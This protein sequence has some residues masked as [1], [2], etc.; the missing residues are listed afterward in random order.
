MAFQQL[1]YTSCEHGLGG[2]AGYQFNAIT[3]GVP[4]AVLREVEERTLYEPPRWRMTDPGADEPDAYPI[5][6]SYGV[7]ETTGTTITAHVVFSGVDYSGR[8]GNYFVHALVSSAP[9]QDFGVLLPVELWGAA[10][11]QRAPIDGTELPE[12]PGPLPRGVIDRPGVQAFLDARG[13]QDVLPELL[14]AIGR[15][16][17]GEQPVLVAS[18]DASENA[19]WIAAASYLMGE[20]VARRMT[21]TTYSHRP[22]YSAYHLV[23]ILAEMLPPDASSSFQLF[24]FTAGRRPGHEPHPLAAILASTGV[25]AAPGLWQQA[26]VFASGTEENLDDWLAP[27]AVAA[28]L[29]GRQL[30]AG[31]MDTVARWLPAAGGWLPP[32]HRRDCPRRGAHPGERSAV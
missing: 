20:H 22:G 12:L 17:A 25:M 14:T 11:W 16:M 9:Q 28:G 3:P 32:Q 2:Y 6:F 19:W 23:G 10:I 29:L 5:A 24:D 21:F 18:K 8:P 27:V 4:A 31:E 13:G 30:S 1:Y 26:T 7:S 15:A